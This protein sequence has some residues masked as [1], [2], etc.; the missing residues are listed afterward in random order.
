M[1]TSI[2]EWR[3]VNEELVSPDLNSDKSVKLKAYQ[4]NLAYY[5]KNKNRFDQILAVDEEKQEELANKLINGN[6]YLGIAWKMAKMEHSIEKAEEDI[7]G[8]LTEEEKTEINNT[9][10]ENKNKLRELQYEL[11]KMIK[12][13]LET[14][15]KL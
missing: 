1:I 13:D 4:D 11:Q 6:A 12:K 3:K 15:K 7:R 8:E 9:N 10:N 14:I 2:N 5:N